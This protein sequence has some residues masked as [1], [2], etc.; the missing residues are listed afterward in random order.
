VTPAGIGTVVDEEEEK[1]RR[2]FDEDE[3]Y[4]ETLAHGFSEQAK[5]DLQK[6]ASKAEACSVEG[7]GTGAKQK[8]VDRKISEEEKLMEPTAE[9]KSYQK[10]QYDKEH[11]K[12][13][14]EKEKLHD[15]AAIIGMGPSSYLL[16]RGVPLPVIYRQRPPSP[17]LG[18]VRDEGQELR[19]RLS[20]PDEE[21]K[22]EELAHQLAASV[23]DQLAPKAARA[24]SYSTSGVGT[25]SKIQEA[26]EKFG[27]ELAQEEK[28]LGRT[29]EELKDLEQ[30]NTNVF[31][32]GPGMKESGVEIKEKIELAT[33]GGKATE[34]VETTAVTPGGEETGLPNPKIVIKETGIKM[35]S[36]HN[37]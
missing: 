18:T 23:K 24:D 32:T 7:V 12:E 1:R 31:Q 16:V 28:R 11:V 27:S 35:K 33:I 10:Y 3:K 22:R 5:R 4:R 26:E 13:Q 21:H 17:L 19:R 34:K 6:F 9:E 29:V 37:P 15:E 14:L 36:T 20:H 8:E 2:S 25:G 30:V